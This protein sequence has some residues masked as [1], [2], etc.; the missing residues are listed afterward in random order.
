MQRIR[1]SA[2]LPTEH[3][4][5]TPSA[6][7]GD[8]DAENGGGNGTGGVLDALFGGISVVFDAT[9]SRLYTCAVVGFLYVR[10]RFWPLHFKA[11]RPSSVSADS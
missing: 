9:G 8:E 3:V 10:C 1:P 4:V 6:T 5:I 7:V 2:T 11:S